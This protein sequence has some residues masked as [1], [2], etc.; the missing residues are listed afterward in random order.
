MTT[1]QHETASDTGETEV[2]ETRESGVRSYCRHFG[3]VFDSARGSLLVDTAGRRYI[4]F[5]AGCS[6]LNYG[7][8]DPDMQHALLNHIKHESVTLGLDLYTT[9]KREFLQRFEDVILTPRGLDYRVQFTGPTGTNA[10]EAALKLARKVT[11]RHSVIAFT[12]GFHGVS[13][14]ALAATGNGYNRAGAHTP[15]NGV[16][17]AFFDGYLGPDVDTVAVLQQLLDDPSSGVAAPAAFI[18]ETVQGEGG[19][20]VASTAWMQRLAALAAAHGSLVIVDDIQAGCGRTGSFFSF[21]SMGI[22]PDIVTLSKSIS[23]FGLPMALV[24]MKPEL[25]TWGPAEHNGTFRGNGMA[26]TTAAVAIEKFWSDDSLSND[27]R[28]RAYVVQSAL[29][30]VALHVPGAQLKGRGMFLGIDVGC[31]ELAGAIC[32]EAFTRGVV[33]ETSGA[34]GQVVKILAPLTTSDM[35]LASG[36]ERVYEAAMAVIA[37]WP[38]SDAPRP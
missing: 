4:D 18:V 20:N 1:N 3:V 24:L 7:H 27:I 23:G 6:A 34:R 12:N 2:F 17:R 36:M 32:R 13:L 28:R 14:G 9:P 26:F 5:L 15:L 11:G 21:E 38:L 35:L 16:D 8:N 19:L 33:I 31:G 22:E 10:V 30:A 29:D 37:R 25:D